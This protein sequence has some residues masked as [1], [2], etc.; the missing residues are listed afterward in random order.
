MHATTAFTYFSEITDCGRCLIS[1]VKNNNWRPPKVVWFTSQQLRSLPLCRC[2]SWIRW[3]R[4]EERNGVENQ[5][6]SGSSPH[7]LWTL[8]ANCM[9]IFEIIGTKDDMNHIKIK[10]RDF[11][12]T[13]TSAGQRMQATQV[14]KIQGTNRFNVSLASFSLASRLFTSLSLTS[15]SLAW[16]S[17]ASLSL[18]WRSCASLSLAWRSCASLSLAW[19]SCAS[20]SFACRSL[21]SRFL[22]SRSRSSLS[23]VSFAALSSSKEVTKV[24]AFKCLGKS[25]DFSNLNFPWKHG[26]SFTKKH[27]FGVTKNHLCDGLVSFAF[28]EVDVYAPDKST[29]PTNINLDLCHPPVLSRSLLGISFILWV[30]LQ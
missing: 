2:T 5:W 22:A 26:N 10:K 4:C 3:T 9:H 14:K 21:A 12:T 15:R 1:I 27:L 25:D 20:L 16:R 24:S 19:R 23:A 17:C 8:R 13:S 30:D 7:P 28:K 11:T 6:G 29:H 18:A